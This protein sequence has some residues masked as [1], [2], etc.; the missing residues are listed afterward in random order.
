MA[1]HTFYST[2]DTTVRYEI[3][4]GIS[5]GT[6]N[7][8][9][10]VVGRGPGDYIYRTAIQFDLSDIPTD[11]YNV[12][13]AVIK[14]RIAAVLGIAAPHGPAIEGIPTIKT[15]LIT[16]TW[17]E[18]S[19]D[20]DASGAGWSTTAPTEW[21]TF[22]NG[23]ANT[24]TGVNTLVDGDT[25]NVSGSGG[26]SGEPGTLISIDVRDPFLYW[27]PTS[28][29]G[30]QAGTNYGVLIHATN[31]S[32]NSQRVNFMSQKADG[33]S[34]PIYF[35]LPELVITYDTP[36]LPNPTVTDV[37]PAGSGARRVA[38]ITN[39]ADTAIWSSTSDYAQAAF[40]WSVTLSNVLSPIKRWG[41]GIYLGSD[42]TGTLVYDTGWVTDS[43]HLDD[44]SFE[45]TSNANK[46]SWITDGWQAGYNGLQRDTVYYWKIDVEDE[47]DQT[48]SSGNVF[49][50]LWGQ[51]LYEFDAGASYSQTSSWL[52][53][54]DTPPTNTQ[55]TEV[56]QATNVRSQAQVTNVS[57]NGTTITYTCAGGHSFV[58]G[59]VVNIRGLSP[60]GYNLSNAIINVAS[61]PTF[62]VQNA[63][64]G[65]LVPGTIGYA[66]L[67]S[68][69]TRTATVSNA[70]GNGTTVTY[71]T[72]SAHGFVA[73][74]K[75]TIT[76]VWPSAYNLANATIAT[77][78]SPNTSTFTVTN[79]ATG[80]FTVGGKAVMHGRR[81]IS[82]PLTDISGNG[83]V[84]TFTGNNDFVAGQQVSI[85]GSNV[86]AFNLTNA[87]VASATAS[88]FTVNGT[89]SQTY[90]IASLT[91][92]GS[93]VTYTTTANHGFAADQL[94]VVAG[95]TPSG[96]NTAATGARI[97][98][99]TNTT[100]TIANAPTGALTVP[101]TARVIPIGAVAESIIT[102]SASEISG[103]ARYLHAHIRTSVDNAS[104][105][106]QPK[107][108]NVQFSYLS[109]V[110]TPDY[111]TAAGSAGDTANIVLDS[112]TRRFG[113][114]SVRITSSTSGDA[115]IY[116][117]RINSGDDISVVPNTIYSFSCYV[118]VGSLSGANNIRLRVYPAGTSEPASA[119]IIADSG[120]HTSYVADN[121]Y[122]RRLSITFTTSSSTHAVRPM[123]Y[124]TNSAG[125]AN[126]YFWADG[127][128]FE[129][130][131][132][133]RS[134]TP[135]FVTSGVTFEGGG[136][137]IDTSRGGVLRLRGGNA[138]ARDQIS[139][140]ARGLLFGGDTNPV[141]VY[142]S[143][144][145]QIDIGGGIVATGAISATDI[146]ASGTVN[147]VTITQPAT[148]STLTIA[149][150]KTLTAS[151]SITFTGTD[152]SSVNV[153]TGGTMMTNPM[154]A[155]GDLIIG[156]TSGAPTR[157]AS[158]TAEFV[159]TAKGAGTAPVWQASA[160]GS[161][162]AYG[163]YNATN[164]TITGIVAGGADTKLIFGTTNVVANSTAGF[165][166][167]DSTDAITVA[168]AGWYHV[169]AGVQTNLV[170]GGVDTLLS[171]Y[172]G[173]ASEMYLTSQTRN[174][175]NMFNFPLVSGIIYLPA[176]ETLQ[177]YF[178]SVG[179]TASAANTVVTEK[180]I[181]VVKV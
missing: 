163:L 152:N 46:P 99:R 69:E 115:F 90:T 109:A 121:E 13:S 83:S 36:P 41:I 8:F 150:G 91:T 1:E 17:T 148:G 73:G 26:I 138:G 70:S 19:T 98:A 126:D 53:D 172:V 103:Q 49:K 64:T 47:N 10:N 25:V 77:V 153:G 155:V 43:A 161:A 147:K 144:S 168:A 89:A 114:K 72:S 132:V 88:A 135:G 40:G 181:H 65:T 38:T 87:T 62:T 67:V 30:G 173:G 52:V 59:D 142:S 113:T 164:Q 95:C 55:A 157:L 112:D 18:G 158:G 178:A 84:I 136:L 116:P 32:L 156:S 94:V 61:S 141:Q 76:G 165:S 129:E 130:G 6:G 29:Q 180:W 11:V 58:A 79:A 57:G 20:A 176:N 122:W 159:L 137:N 9:H 174:P 28:V 12:T 169:S 33:E 63:A 101:G 97:T 167:T 123:I 146:T 81:G 106:A 85:T 27:A 105:S 110:Q 86:S 119:N 75:V 118:K 44:L 78:G 117:F 54:Y 7:D 139:V 128:L 96:Y 50:V 34:F 37:Y 2:K 104:S 82:D 48:D 107:L 171:V 93:A 166:F 175:T 5:T 56:Y 127:I 31:E 60:D 71:T 42:D 162:I 125:L 15:S 68:Y 145:G 51:A 102:T 124:M 179:A 108:N 3:S 134:W 45:T 151:N 21:T 120:P 39:L 74:Q 92:T 170:A 154:S 66:T 160:A 23:G 24:F 140:G 14:M 4:G 16:K 143:A 35:Y 111:W 133:V 22:A 131:T 149:N 80:T 100:F 177:L